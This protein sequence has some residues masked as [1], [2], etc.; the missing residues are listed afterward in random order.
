MWKCVG[1]LPTFQLFVGPPAQL[2]GL[3]CELILDKLVVLTGRADPAATH[4]SL[5]DDLGSENMQRNVRYFPE[6]RL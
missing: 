3:A 4:L 6:S 1:L 2:T 5:P